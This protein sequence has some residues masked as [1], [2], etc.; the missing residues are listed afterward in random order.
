MYEGTIYVAGNIASLG[1]D[2]KVEEMT[3]DELIDLL[4]ILESRGITDKRRFTKVVSAK[5]VLQLRLT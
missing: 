2:A 5:R 3:E 4:S 1:A